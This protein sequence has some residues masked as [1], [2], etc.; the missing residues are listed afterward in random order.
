MKNYW[1]RTVGEFQKEAHQIKEFCRESRREALISLIAAF[2]LYGT[3]LV[4]KNVT[5]DS[6]VMYTQPMELLHSWC[7][8]NRYGLV[9]TKYLFH[10]LQY[11]QYL[12]VFLMILTLWSAGL[13]VSYCVS[14]WS[15]ADKNWKWF[16]LVFTLLFLSAPCF[17]EQAYFSLQA[18]EVIWGFFVCIIAAYSTGKLIYQREN[19]LWGVLG[20]AGMVWAFGT[21]QSIAVVF[22]ALI[23]ISFLI[24]YGRDSEEE[25]EGEESAGVKR[26]NVWFQRACL[27]ALFFLAGFLLYLAAG[28]I[29][30]M[31]A[32]VSTD[33]VNDMIRWRTDGI[34]VCLSNI[35]GDMQRVLKGQYPCYRKSFVFLMTGAWILLIYRG[36]KGRKKEKAIY[37]LA[38]CLLA[39][40]PFFMTFLSGSYQSAR[41]QLVYPLVYAFAG[42]YL[43]TVGNK[44]RTVLCVICLYL[45]WCQGTVTVQLL[46]T[47]NKV[48]DQDQA[49]A[50]EI[51]ER[52]EQVAK[53][54]QIIL[55]E[56]PIVFVGGRG[57]QL[58]SGDVLRGEM[59][60]N[61]MFEWGIEEPGGVTYRVRGLMQSWGLVTGSGDLREYD[62]AQEIAKTMDVWPADSSVVY[63]RGIMVVKLSEL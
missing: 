52:M 48:S 32:G 60:G 41:A 7:G 55:E 61:S 57:A 4:H 8:I 22:I 51:Y 40:S 3:L 44:T 53:E 59:I 6:E 1:K 25:T 38:S 18:F 5:V 58:E 29:I 56:C 27:L 11:S 39:V 21:Y 12:S 2:A 50:Y 23:L 45:A 17:A 19:A 24:L 14:R 54:N 28:R 62:L 30:Q 36:I 49:R 35:Y 31:I 63:E 10:M 37:I 33:Y 46:E 13:A 43:T 26:R 16:T 9:I 47:V 20:L 42:A 34:R 15:G